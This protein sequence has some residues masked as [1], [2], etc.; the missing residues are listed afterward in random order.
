MQRV[1]KKLKT[2]YLKSKLSTV[3]AWALRCLE[4]VYAN[5]TGDEKAFGCAKHNN[6]VGFTGTDAEFMTSL[7]QQYERRKCLSPKQMVFV[8]KRM[9]KYWKQVLTVTEDQKL[10]DC[11]YRDGILT[12]EDVDAYEQKLFVEAMG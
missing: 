6:N 2:A 9:P 1:T 10:V 5:Q 3:P 11:M 4:V 12:K 8:L 7:A